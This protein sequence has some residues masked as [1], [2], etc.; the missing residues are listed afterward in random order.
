MHD[1]VLVAV[2]QRAPNLP[3]ELACD[4]FPQSPVADDVVEHLAPADVFEHHVVMVLV[5]DH[6]AHAADVWVMEEHRKR[7]FTERPY[8][9][10]GIFRRLFRCRIG[11]G[12]SC[13]RVGDD[14]GENFDR[15]LDS[16]SRP[17]TVGTGFDS[18]SPSRP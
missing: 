2:V 6:L 15:E 13:G 14:S 10:R 1:V 3:C 8:L 5:N 11:S 16:K 9:L 18:C 12:R 4:S 7:G 17:R